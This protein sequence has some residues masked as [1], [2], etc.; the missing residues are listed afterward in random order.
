MKLCQPV[1]CESGF[2]PA[3]VFWKKTKQISIWKLWSDTI[4]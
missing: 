2:H 4:T 1:P 3:S